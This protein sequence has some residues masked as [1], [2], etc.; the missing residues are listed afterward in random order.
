MAQS[1]AVPCIPTREERPP[2]SR[3]MGLGSGLQAWGP[4]DGSDLQRDGWVRT[5]GPE[6]GLRTQEAQLLPRPGLRLT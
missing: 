5:A 1:L 6:V 3:E 2:A 4:A